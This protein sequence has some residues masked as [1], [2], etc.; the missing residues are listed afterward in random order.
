ML[1]TKKAEAHVVPQPSA[2]PALVRI[3]G[4]IRQILLQEKEHFYTI[5]LNDGT[6]TRVAR[7]G[8]S[9]TGKKKAALSADCPTYSLTEKAFFE[10]EPICQPSNPDDPLRPFTLQERPL[11][12]PLLGKAKLAAPCDVDQALENI[13]AADSAATKT[14]AILVLKTSGPTTARRRPPCPIIS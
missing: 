9:Y 11:F 3:S 10:N 4:H 1:A 13:L 12:V 2:L 8:D 7:F 6:T 14:V 5:C